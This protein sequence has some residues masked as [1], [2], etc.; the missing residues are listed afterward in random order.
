MRGNYEAAQFLID[1]GIDMTICD[2]RWNATAEGWAC[3]AA[4]DK[5][6]AEFLARAQSARKAQSP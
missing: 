3:H 2:Y 5:N 4:K 1:H 6:M